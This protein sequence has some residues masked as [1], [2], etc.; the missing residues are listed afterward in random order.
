MKKL[1]PGGIRCDCCRIMGGTRPTKKYLVRAERRRQ[2]QTRH[3][4]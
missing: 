2:K 1:G 4:S 3:T